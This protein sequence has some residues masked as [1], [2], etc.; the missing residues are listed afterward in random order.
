MNPSLESKSHGNRCPNLESKFKSMMTNRFGDPDRLSFL[1]TLSLHCLHHRV[2]TS[3]FV[4]PRRSKKLSFSWQIPGPANKSKHIFIRGRSVRG[5]SPER[6]LE[7]GEKWTILHSETSL[8]K[9]LTSEIR[10]NAKIRTQ[11]CP[12]QASIL[13]APQVVYV[14]IHN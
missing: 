2:Q 12:Y 9:W 14:S 6:A 8:L 5:S 1:F 3:G 10:K 13:P 7:D 4:A 11:F